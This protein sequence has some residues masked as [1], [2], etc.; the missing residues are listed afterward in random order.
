MAG[1]IFISY[2]R[3]RE[4]AAAVVEAGLREQG[5]AGYQIFRDARGLFAGESFNRQLED[6]LRRTKVVLLLVGEGDA[7]RPEVDDWVSTELRAAIRSRRPILPVALGS[8]G[9]AE[10]SKE[11]PAEFKSIAET[12]FLIIKEVPDSEDFTRLA[13]ALRRVGV[14][15]RKT[16]EMWSTILEHNL[17]GPVCDQLLDFALRKPPGTIVL[18]G[19]TGS[20][21]S[22]VMRQVVTRLRSDSSQPAVGTHDGLRNRLVGVDN[23]A[24][25]DWLDGL[26]ADV[27]DV[28]SAISDLVVGGL[29]REHLS[30]TLLDRFTA[31]Q[32]SQLRSGGANGTDRGLDTLGGDA[33]V[34]AIDQLAP[35]Y[36]RP[37]VLMVDDIDLADSGSQEIVRRLARRLRAPDPPPVHVVLSAARSPLLEL[38]LKDVGISDRVSMTPDVRSMLSDCKLFEAPTL[39]LL[40]AQGLA[41]AEYPVYLTHL[42]SRE[43]LVTT[44]DGVWRATTAA[45]P[46]LAEALDDELANVY[47]PSLQQIIEIGALC[48][49]RFDVRIADR[50]ASNDKCDTDTLARL[51][52]YDQ[53]CVILK[54]AVGLGPNRLSFSSSMWWRHLRSRRTTDT[55]APR[56]PADVRRLAETMSAEILAGV[57]CYDDWATVAFLY[58]SISDNSQAGAAF[59]RAARAARLKKANDAAARGYSEAARRLELHAIASP[60]GVDRAGELLRAAYCRFRAATITDDV[61]P[62]SVADGHDGAGHDG[63]DGAGPDGA[64]MDPFTAVMDLLSGV[65]DEFSLASRSTPTDFDDAVTHGADLNSET[66]ER[67]HL[68]WRS[69]TAFVE[70]E[71]GRRTM[72]SQPA[73]ALASFARALVLGETGMSGSVYHEI[74]CAASAGLALASSSQR[75]VPSSGEHAVA[76]FEHGARAAM[77]LARS[78]YAHTPQR[79]E[80]DRFDEARTWVGISR[81]QLADRLQRPGLGVGAG[82]EPI[83]EQ[84]LIKLLKATC[85]LT[86]GKDRANHADVVAGNGRELLVRA[87]DLA[88]W[89]NC[90]L[91][92]RDIEIYALTHD[93]FRMT[94]SARLLRIWRDLG[95][96]DQ[97]WL[98]SGA[99][100]EWHNPTLLH[101]KIAAQ[102][103]EHDL[104]LATIVGQVR[105]ERLTY[106]IA[107]HSVGA[108]DLDTRAAG[109]FIYAVHL[110]DICARHKQDAE[111][112]EVWDLAF[113]PGGLRAAYVRAHAVRASLLK[114]AGK[115][116]SPITAEIIAAR[117]PDALRPMVAA[118]R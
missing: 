44:D 34:N 104:R 3:R 54:D 74:V 24:V 83:D 55:G 43:L 9:Q 53:E 81:T 66:V 65:T 41:P 12:Q 71:R 91:F 115:I 100:T 39:E 8:K 90:A 82:A 111:M 118:G 18:E 25:Y 20:G 99:D 33:V 106:A 30:R 13:G 63:P 1:E 37:I 77:L 110:A 22:H 113:E 86:A 36:G 62:A 114:Q 80:R 48:G 107:T 101:G 109:P 42:Q 102:W 98:E 28:P 11:W 59:L 103:L 73:S 50:V 6:A 47:P 93:Q 72:T 27:G 60:A 14:R 40:V 79:N 31:K 87:A 4:V 116:L 61:A 94:D 7:P 49:P 38:F 58:D 52:N 21:R 96:G 57:E 64:E 75:E 88:D 46:S 2:R 17:V 92:Q 5:Y 84:A 68:Q 76:A 19:L 108:R 45:L 16:F 26:L 85:E 15:P 29:Q 67:L 32:R 97:S 105:F 78:P 95:E 89:Q 69:L 51:L 117:Q 23:A 112:S 10:L 56:D 70:I 35:V